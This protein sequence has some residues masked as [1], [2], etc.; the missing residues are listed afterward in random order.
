MLWALGVIPAVLW[1]VVAAGRRQRAAEARLA[2]PRLFAHLAGMPVRG[3]ARIP[4]LLYL[5]AL[6]LLVVAMARPVALIPLPTNRAGLVLAVDTSQSMMADDVKPSRLEAAK[7]AAR[8]LARSLPRSLQI[9]LVAFSDV[10]AVL[11]VPTTDRRL[12]DEALE[13]LRPQQ[14]T[15]MG[16]AV[17]EGLAVLPGRREFLGERLARLRTQ[18]APDPLSGVP[19]QIPAVPPQAGDL[20]PAAIVIFSDGVTNTGVDPRLTAAL[21]VEARVRVHTVG[22]GQEGGAVMPFA[23]RM[24]LVPFDSASL[25]ELAQR[26]GG[27]HLRAVD[28]E[29]IRRIARELNRSVGWE[30]RKT[31]L[32]ALLAG[33]AAAIMTGGAALS[34]VWFR[35][36]P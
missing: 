6:T 35:R 18:A 27:E 12:L 28:E 7:L 14:S 23:G 17:V 30:R 4:A 5:I 26:T 25:Q 16:S 15:A 34:L 36:V 1:G 20:P 9:G 29:A 33:L 24:V 3:R 22:M 19:P 13:R 21:A 11:L 2:D 31:E 32:T 10:G 8:A